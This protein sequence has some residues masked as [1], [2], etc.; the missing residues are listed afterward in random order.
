MTETLGR[1]DVLGAAAI[2]MTAAV[3]SSEAAAQAPAYYPPAPAPR[4]YYPPQANAAPGYA[5]YA[6]YPAPASSPYA[7]P[8][9]QYP[10]ARS[11]APNAYNPPP[12]P[13][14]YAQR[15]PYDAPRYPQYGDEYD[16]R[17]RA[18]NGYYRQDGPSGGYYAPRH[19]SY[20]QPYADNYPYSSPNQN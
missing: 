6:Y 11:S 15:A 1:R 2:A 7:P 14:S 16:Y 3:I 12:A 9:G 17:D 10:Q 19:R 18:Y 13:P 5:P 8:L 4:N 20:G